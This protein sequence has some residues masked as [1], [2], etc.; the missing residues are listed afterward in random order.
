V[1]VTLEGPFRTTKLIWTA[2]VGKVA[3]VAAGASYVDRETE[4]RLKQSLCP[5]PVV[6][7][8]ADPS[9][10]EAKA[11]ADDEAEKPPP[12]KRRRVNLQKEGDR[13]FVADAMAAAEKWLADGAEGEHVFPPANGFLRR[14]LYE[15]S[16]RTVILIESSHHGGH[17]TLQRL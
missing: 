1:V 9:T 15:R 7:A 2:L 10:T 11:A 17:V 16:V 8:A 12:K 3:L 14:A 6:V 4:G 13:Q 5:E